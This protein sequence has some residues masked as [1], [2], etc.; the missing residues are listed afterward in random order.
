M[1]IAHLLIDYGADVNI[2]PDL[3]MTPLMLAVHLNN[4]QLV[5]KLIDR[6]ADV[7]AAGKESNS[8]LSIAASEGYKKIYDY[9]LP[10][11]NPNYINE[12]LEEGV[13]CAITGNQSLIGI[14]F[15]ASVNANLNCGYFNGDT[16]LIKTIIGKRFSLAKK[17]IEVGADVNFK[18]REGLTALSLAKAENHDE[19]VQ[20]LLNVGAIYE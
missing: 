6:G 8:P 16:P 14:E 1:N 12:F 2:D 17:L 18:T 7:N 19:I 15:L 4:L 20:A 13:W 11:V 10:L 3:D 9:L 5:K